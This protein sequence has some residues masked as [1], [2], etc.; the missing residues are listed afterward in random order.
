MAPDAADPAGAGLDADYFDGRSAR[1]WPVRL[2][3]AGTLLTIRGEGIE[4]ELPWHALRWPERSRHGVRVAELPDGGML[5]CHDAVAWDAFVRA[6][7]ATE[8]WV[9]RLQQSWRA[10][11]ASLLATAALLAALY[12]WGVPW[13]AGRA[14]AFVP[15][16]V[17]RS[18]GAAALEALD[19]EM[20]QPSALPAAQRAALTAAFAQLL[21]AQPAG[22]LPA[23]RLEFRRSRIG[24]NAFAL[25]GGTIVLTDEL[26]ER[27]DGDAAIVSG[28]L[29]HEFGHLRG[30]HGMRTVLQAGALG[31]LAGALLGD[32][33]T[34]LAAA[35]V[36]L[37]Q[38]AYSRD[39]ERE[40]DA[41]AARLLRD[42]GLSP[43]L[44]ATFFEKLA[45]R[46]GSGPLIGIGSHPADAERIRFFREYR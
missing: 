18:I 40:A 10:V 22:S 23:W 21:A 34:L 37:G 39:A 13:A 30:R 31:V 12:A 7:G 44:M 25:P 46:P 29:A 5:Q 26:V 17:D 11:L 20:L 8:P 33:S 36:V 41:E 1:A 2:G 4:R 14:L 3:R 45:A 24:P 35:P 16:A 19:A 28:V 9:V 27:V 6:G 15:E 32:F 38:A 42:A 43:A